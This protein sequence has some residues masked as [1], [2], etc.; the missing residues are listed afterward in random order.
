[1]DHLGDNA[2]I[3]DS[4]IP[5]IPEFSQV[6]GVPADHGARGFTTTRWF[7][8]YSV[9][10]LFKHPLYDGGVDDLSI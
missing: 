5:V 8:I 9:S 4:E 2:L 1:M 10:M 3:P 7:T 6:L